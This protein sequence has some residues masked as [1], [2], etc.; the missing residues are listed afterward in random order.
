MALSTVILDILPEPVNEIFGGDYLLSVEF[1]CVGRLESVPKNSQY[2]IAWIPIVFENV[3]GMKSHIS[4]N[5]LKPSYT[6]F[7][8]HFAGWQIGQALSLK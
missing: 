8:V 1:G 5:H 7:I 3:M 6:V 2:T 4:R